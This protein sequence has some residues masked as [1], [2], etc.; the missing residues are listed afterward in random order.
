MLGWGKGFGCNVGQVLPFLRCI[1]PQWDKSIH[2]DPHF[3]YVSHFVPESARYVHTVLTSNRIQHFIKHFS[4]NT[5][6]FV[7]HC[8]AFSGWCVCCSTKA[9]LRRKLWT[10]HGNDTKGKTAPHRICFKEK[11]KIFN[12]TKS[13]P[14]LSCK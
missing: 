13:M 9:Y 12:E 4:E 11:N 14:F 10:L 7:Y 8:I 1:S 3:S 2:I 5:I 6:N